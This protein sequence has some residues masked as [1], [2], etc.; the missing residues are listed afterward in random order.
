[1]KKI[2]IFVSSPSDVEH[3]RRICKKV[4]EQLNAMLRAHYNVYLDPYF[5]ENSI[6]STGMGRPQGR[7]PSPENFDLYIGILWKRFGTPTGEV[8]PATGMVNKSGTEEEFRLAYEAWKKT[9]HVKPEIKFLHKRVEE[10]PELLA[11]EQ[12]IQVKKFL[13]NFNL[14]GEHPGLYYTFDSDVE[15]ESVVQR[16][17]F[18]YVMESNQGTELPKHYRSAGI[19]DLFLHSDNENRNRSKKE[20]LSTSNHIRLIAHSGNSFLNST[21]QRFFSLV[22]DCLHRGGRVDVILANPYSEMGYYITLGDTN[23]RRTQ[24]TLVDFLHANKPENVIDS[25]E[26]TAWVAYKLYP[27]IDGYLELR[28]VF[29]DKIR[30]RMCSYEMNSTILLTEQAAYHEPYMHC[31]GSEHGMNAFEIRVEKSARAQRDNFYDALS[32]YFNF[33]WEISEDYDEF[34]QRE[35]QN[36]QCLRERMT[37]KAAGPI[38]V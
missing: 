37:E 15:F 24:K 30:L 10:T 33:L 4:L 29:G 20:D 12:Y 17:V 19:T 31:V 9:N 27:A 28:G 3:E 36:E 6:E 38:E 21:S 35:A 7:I 34:V 18:N 22:E 16:Y 11:D 1:M 32:E 26:R 8:D 2:T 5:W 23:R 14:E 25:I 13:N